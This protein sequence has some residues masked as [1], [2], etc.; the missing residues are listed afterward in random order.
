MKRDADISIDTRIEPTEQL[1]G[2][3]ARFLA[4]L[5]GRVRELRERHAMSRKRL[6]R[7]SRVSERYL[8]QIETGNGN[9]SIML[10]KRVAA[11]LGASAGDLLAA[12]DHDSV[13]RRLIRRFLDRLPAHRL[14]EVIF[15][16]MR[17]F[18]HEEAARRK[19][20]A[21]IGLR[22]AGKSTLGGMLAR[23]LSMPL[24][25][26]N[27]EIARETGLPAGEVMALYGLAAYRR[28]EQR[29]LERVA[30]DQER[31]VIVAG[32]GIVNEDEAFNLLLA[33]CYTVWI[34]AQPEEHMAR[35]LAQGDFRPMAG[36]AEAMDDLKRILATR[37]A[38]YRKADAIVD[39]SGETPQQSFA[40]LREAVTA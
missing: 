26:L 11:A 15:R 19:R 2:E 35:V 21:L 23:A 40:R 36:N 9:I 27:R 14:E 6:A 29:V 33:N 12:D 13:Q 30:R 37:E 20:I 17:D 22:G 18:G 1:S 25:E 10:L 3:D 31:A 34:R 32:G 38:M 7:D 8:A 28:I 39:T 16:L 5:G 4:D 24:I